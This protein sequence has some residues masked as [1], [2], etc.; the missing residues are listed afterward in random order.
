MPPPNKE[1]NRHETSP[2]GWGPI[3]RRVGRGSQDHLKI[4]LTAGFAT[5]GADHDAL[6]GQ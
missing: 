5:F 1:P 3:K 2:C 6:P 4:I